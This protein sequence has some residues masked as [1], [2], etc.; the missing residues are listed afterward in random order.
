MQYNYE[1]NRIVIDRTEIF[2]SNVENEI[3]NYLY[4]HRGKMCSCR[5]ISQYVYGTG[6]REKTVRIW[7]YRLRLKLDN[8]LIIRSVPK[9]GY[10]IDK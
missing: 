6:D 1:T 8:K 9:K 3:F 7:M 2:L 4:E 5:D 10:V